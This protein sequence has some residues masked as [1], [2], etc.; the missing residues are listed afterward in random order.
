[1][2][3]HSNV[4]FASHSIIQYLQNMESDVVINVLP[5]SFDYGLYQLLM[6]FQFG[7]TLVL[8]RSFAYPAAF[9]KLMEKE[10]VTAFPGVPTLF[11]LLVNHDL[12]QYDLSALRY[13]TNTAAALPPA[14]VEAIRCK[15]PQAKLFLMYGLTET[16]RTLYLP[17]EQLNAR[18]GSVGIPIPGTE[19]WIEDESGQRLGPGMVGE[20]V[21][22]GRHVMRGY[23]ESP[24]ATA[25]RFRAGPLPGERLCYT[26]DLF[27]QDEEGFFYFVG[28]KDDIIKCRGEKVAPK[29]VENVLYELPGVMTAAVLG[30]PDPVLGQAIKAVLVLN[31]QAQLSPAAVLAH[32]RARLEDFMVPKYV[33]FRDSLPTT[34][35]GKIAKKGLA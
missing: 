19:A 20:L 35:S 11:A 33:E 30:V 22:R 3:D 18:P 23:W 26:G 6:T 29:E 10:R 15:F 24:E 1:M 12:S 14:H 17:P 8:E 32:C 16:K 4:V 25:Q 21:V 27:F 28:R 7:G 9:L 31:P 13:L 2:C 5:L 34:T